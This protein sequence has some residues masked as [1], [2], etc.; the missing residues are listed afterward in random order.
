MKVPLGEVN[1][2]GLSLRQ[3]DFHGYAAGC[4]FMQRE[5]M[6]AGGRVSAMCMVMQPRWV[7][8]AT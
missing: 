5:L 8:G 6:G 2:S 3:P 7:C 4:M 1:W